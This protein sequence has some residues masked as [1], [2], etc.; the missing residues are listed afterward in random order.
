MGEVAEMML[1]GL[2]CSGCGACFDDEESPGHPRKCAE[3]REPE[4]KQV[5]PK[6]RRARKGRK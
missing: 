2:L 4:P 3:C 1:E 6:P 5:A